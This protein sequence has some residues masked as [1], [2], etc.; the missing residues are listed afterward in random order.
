MPFLEDIQKDYGTDK[1][2]VV[3]I[4]HMERGAGDPA[5]YTKTLNFEQVSVMEGG[6]IGDAYSVAFHSRPNDRR[7]G[8][9]H[10]VETKIHRSACRP[11]K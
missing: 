10:G 3:L 11:T 9:S 2:N 4:N 6:S 1:I 5:A 8:R 7:C